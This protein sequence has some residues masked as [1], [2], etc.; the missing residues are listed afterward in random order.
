MRKERYNIFSATFLA[1][2]AAFGAVSC[3]SE[4]DNL[5]L[6]FFENGAATGKE[7]LYDVVAY[8]HSNNDTIQADEEKLQEAT[9]GAFDEPVFGLQKSAFVTQVRLSS[10]SPDFGTNPV[11]DS[12]VLQVK[13]LYA[14]DSVTTVT[15]EAYVHADGNVPAKKVVSTYPIKKYG[16]TKI[17]GKTRLTINVNEVTEFLPSPETNVFSNQQVALG[18]LLGT[19]T[20][21]GT[22]SSVKI[23]KDSD[24]SEILVRDAALRIPLSATFFQEKIINKRNSFE[25]SDV[26]S[27]IR[28]FKGLRLSVEE[29]DGYIFNFK[30]AELSAIIYYKND[31]T[32]NNT[33]TRVPSSFSLDLSGSN[34]YFNQISYTR[35]ATFTTAVSSPNTT[36]GDAKLYLQG[37]GGPGAVLRIPA[38]AIAALK[39]EY[40][41][42]KIGIMG[43]RLRLYTDEV[44]WNNKYE[45]PSKFLVRYTN[46]QDFIDDVL[47]FANF[48]SFQHVYASDL[49]KNPVYYDITLTKTIKD[50]VETEKEARDLLINVGDYIRA[51]NGAYMGQTVN[52]RPFDPH[53]V[54]LVGT[55]ALNAKRAQLRVTYSTK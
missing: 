43:A 45:K 38:Q 22:V 52:T 50:I 21:D 44:L 48:A 42:K 12:V 18:A 49:T 40:N 9:L 53:R 3:E 41:S 25:L 13:P 11:V 32:E 51:S 55:D 33:T 35:P 8:N 39:D 36:A 14:A 37:M 6:Q 26:A 54:V 34:V 10:Y 30:P 31:K 5:G 24:N 4:A 29:N 17:N 7:L 16:K 1:L 27:F 46:S 2:F 23:T 28:Y 15:D 47:A 19:K 20:F